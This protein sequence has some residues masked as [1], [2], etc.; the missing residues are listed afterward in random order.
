MC[1]KLLTMILLAVCISTPLIDRSYAQELNSKSTSNTNDTLQT[2]KKNFYIIPYL[3][4]STIVGNFGIEFQ[5]KNY[6]Y[7]IGI[8]KSIIAIDNS[9]C[10]GI[11]Y[12]FKPYH[13]SLVVGLGGG[14]ALDTPK[15]DDDLCGGWSGEV[16]DDW[17]C[18][19]G[20]VIDMYVGIL[21]GYRWICWDKLHLNIGAGPTYIK[22]KKIKEGKNADYLPM[23]DFVIGYSF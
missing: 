16:P 20:S 1:H 8:L 9:L 13:H 11:K 4:V 10:G 3:G 23:L 12:Y 18:N 22:W 15:P 6:G 19:T 2:I 5:H 7:N 14:I 21:I 17:E